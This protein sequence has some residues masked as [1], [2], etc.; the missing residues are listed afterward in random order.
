MLRAKGI[1]PQKEKGITEEQIVQMIEQTIEEKQK[2]SEFRAIYI[3]PI[4]F[5]TK[6]PYLNR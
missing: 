1:I 3:L 6:N 4:V 2:K 5:I